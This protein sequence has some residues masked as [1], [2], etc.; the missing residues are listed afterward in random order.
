MIKSNKGHVVTV[1][2][3]DPEYDF[4]R[5]CIDNLYHDNISSVLRFM[6]REQMQLRERDQEDLMRDSDSLTIFSP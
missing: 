1:R 5:S 4:L 6:V 3:S 2:F